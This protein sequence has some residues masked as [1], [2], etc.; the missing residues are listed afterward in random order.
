MALKKLLSKQAGHTPK[1]AGHTPK[2]A[3]HT[4]KQAGHTPKQAGHTPKHA[5]YIFVRIPSIRVC[6]TCPA[7]CVHIVSLIQAFDCLQ[8]TN[9][10]RSTAKN[11]RFQF[12][13]AQ[14]RDV[15]IRAPCDK[16]V[17]VTTAWRVLG[18]RMEEQAPVRRVDVNILNKQPR[19]PDTGWSSSLGVGRGANNSSP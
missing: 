7:C 11:C 14:F 1:Q 18:L 15:F 8:I 9:T 16:W 13:S 19:T 10:H 3:G 17:S 6:E 5:A 12:M 2:Q 4:P